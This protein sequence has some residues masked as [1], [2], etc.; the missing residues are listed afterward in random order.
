MAKVNLNRLNGD[1]VAGFKKF[2]KKKK[3]NDW[4]D[5]EFKNKKRYKNNG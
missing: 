5:D 3:N 1:E 4:R 2:I